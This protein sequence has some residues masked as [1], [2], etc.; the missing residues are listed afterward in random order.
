MSK[1]IF[2]TQGRVAVV[3]DDW[4]EYL[5]QWKW[6]VSDG[7]AVR[8]GVQQQGKR[9]PFIRMHRVVN[10]TP[11]GFDTDH[12]DHDKLNNQ[13]ANLRTATRSQNLANSTW[14]GNKSGAKGVSFDRGRYRAQLTVNRKKVNLGYFE[15]IQEASD[16]YWIAAKNLLG[17][18][19]MTNFQPITKE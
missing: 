6:C 18:F 14:S 12:V 15:T 10:A 17:E 4:Y 8:N 11:D 1:E 3:D 2:L 7:Y 19:A 5:N 16:A 9:P 13:S